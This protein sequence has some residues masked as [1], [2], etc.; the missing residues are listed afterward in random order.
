M[1]EHV[2]HKNYRA[3]MKVVRRCLEPG[4]LFL[5][6]TIGSKFSQSRTDPWLTR[7]IFPNGMLPSP[8]QI[9]KATEGQLNLEDWHNFPQDYERTLMCWYENF[10]GA[11]GELRADY[12]NASSECGGIIFSRAPA[13]T[14][15][16]RS[17]SLEMALRAATCRR[18]FD[19]ASH[20]G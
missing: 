1:F 5:L 9:S 3:Y 7:Y 13:A 18:A 19:R 16:G 4:G 2:G 11:W 17:S 6:H 10:E 15:Y 8:S 20:P 12:A 14:S